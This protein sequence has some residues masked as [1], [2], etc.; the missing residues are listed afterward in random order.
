RVGGQPRLHL[1]DAPDR[2][3]ITLTVGPV[4]GEQLEAAGDVVEDRQVFGAKESALGHR[5]SCTLGAREP[6]EVARGL[7]AEISD[8]PAMEA[9]DAPHG[10]CGLGGHGAE[11]RQR[12]SVA[13]LEWLGL[14]ADEG[15]ARQALAALDAL[16]QKARRAWRTQER[17]CA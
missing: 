7:V 12:V 2:R 15:V 11:G 3:L 14:E 9:W 16:E 17:V 8:G 13:Q 6:L 5:R 10:R 1:V 4:N